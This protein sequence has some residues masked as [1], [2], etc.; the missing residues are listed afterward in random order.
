M[1]VS[2]KSPRHPT[3]PLKFPG[4][5]SQIVHQWLP[6]ASTPSAVPLFCPTTLANWLQRHMLFSDH[7]VLTDKGKVMQQTGRQTHSTKCKDCCWRSVVSGTSGTRFSF[8]PLFIGTPTCR[9]IGPIQMNDRAIGCLIN[10]AQTVPCSKVGYMIESIG[11]SL[12]CVCVH[13]SM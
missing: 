4:K 12:H 11:T 2:L 10:S 8:R 3:Y 9:L 5:S 13:V 7:Y 1:P 6:T